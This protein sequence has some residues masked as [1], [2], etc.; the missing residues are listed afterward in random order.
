MNSA[1]NIGRTHGGDAPDAVHVQPWISV[2][3]LPATVA[4]IRSFGVICRLD[5]G[6]VVED[7]RG[8]AAPLSASPQH[9]ALDRLI[10]GIP[11]QV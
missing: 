4:V 6:A 2:V 11:R 5:R 1:C 8:H 3:G 9:H 7:G 10:H